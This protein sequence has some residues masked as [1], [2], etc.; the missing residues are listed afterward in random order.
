M[1]IRK[2]SA[3]SLVLLGTLFTSSWAAAQ[4]ALPVPVIQQSQSEWCWA[5]SAQAILQYHQQEA[6]SQCQIADWL[7]M[8]NGWTDSSAGRAAQPDSNYC[9]QYPSSCDFAEDSPG[10]SELLG[11]FDIPGAWAAGSSGSPPATFAQL[12]T[13]LNRG[14]PIIY[15]K[16]WNSGG[17]HVEVISGWSEPGGVPTLELMDPGSAQYTMVTYAELVGGTGY[18]SYWYTV[19]FTQTVNMSAGTAVVAYGGNGS[20]SVYQFEAGHTDLWTNVDNQDP[21]GPWTWGNQASPSGVT[22]GPPE[23]VTFILNAQQYLLGFT[24]GS[25]NNLWEDVWNGSSWAWGNLGQPSGATPVSLSAVAWEENTPTGQNW[26]AKP[27]IHVMAEAWSVPNQGYYLYRDT[28]N[29]SSWSWTNA[30]SVAMCSA[31]AVVSYRSSANQQRMNAFYMDCHGNMYNYWSPDGVSFYEGSLG[32]APGA[33]TGNPSA[34]AFHEGFGIGIYVWLVG[35]NGHLYN[36]YWNDAYGGGWNWTDQ[37]APSGV[38]L[39]SGWYD[40]NAVSA[41]TYRQGGVQMHDVFTYGTNGHL[42]DHHWNGS[43]WDWQDQ[44]TPAS[45]VGVMG[46]VQTSSYMAPGSSTTTAHIRTFVR[47]GDY[48]MYSNAFNGTSWSWTNMEA[49]SDIS[50]P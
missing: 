9:C 25:D 1:H 34:T 7:E 44:G 50:T 14:D 3:G 20:E 4:V 48:Q 45:G 31:P 47:G 46:Q 12:Q 16:T 42:Y 24:V 39:T 33:T 23:A 29:G 28:W 22:V 13:E 10:A 40:G 15:D 43:S 49:P 8:N 21:T 36:L 5:T 30:S 35:T 26:Y 6:I 27:N 38:T 11:E 2:F 37:G 18:P 41:T 19:R 32:A 17:G